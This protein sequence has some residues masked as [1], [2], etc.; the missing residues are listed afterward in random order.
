MQQ[1]YVTP[2]WW[3]SQTTS[4]SP[5]GNQDQLRLSFINSFK[6]GVQMFRNQ[7]RLLGRLAPIALVAAALSTPQ[8]ASQVFGQTRTVAAANA[9]L[10]LTLTADNNVVTACADG[11]APQV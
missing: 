1:T 4:G 3:R 8:L 7:F 11:G 2:T 6:S 9:P 5:S 10:S